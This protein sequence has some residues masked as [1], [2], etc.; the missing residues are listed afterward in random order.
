M[1]WRLRRTLDVIIANDASSHHWILIY[2]NGR[3]LPFGCKCIQWADD[4]PLDAIASNVAA[5][6]HMTELLVSGK[7]GVNAAFPV[8]QQPCSLGR[9][10]LLSH[11]CRKFGS[12][13]WR[14]EHIGWTYRLDSGFF[15]STAWQVRYGRAVWGCASSA[16][17]YV[18]YANLHGSAHPDWRQGGR[19]F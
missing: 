1:S 19:S 18:R 3:R 10:V 17:S 2:P 13:D 7:C 4:G 15:V 14:P 16:G 5:S 12:Q 9:P 11:R 8:W 6:R